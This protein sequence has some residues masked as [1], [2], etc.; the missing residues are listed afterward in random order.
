MNVLLID[1]SARLVAVQILGDKQVLTVD[2]GKTGSTSSRIMPTIESALSQAGLSVKDLDV[3]ASISGP[4]S[5]T[6]LRIGVSVA[7]GLAF[8]LGCKRLP[9]PLLAA[10]REGAPLAAIPS[11]NGF[12]YT[13]GAEYAEL[14]VEDVAEQESV[15]TQGSGAK[16]VLSQ[17]EVFARCARYV[18]SHLDE[19]SERPIEPMYLKKCQAEREREG[20]A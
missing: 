17:E 7:N 16:I 19:A 3:V 15:G 6:G 9:V 11:R 12:S 10:I 20:K 13:L 8:G 18:L 5:F 4:G 2:E 14:S 1:T